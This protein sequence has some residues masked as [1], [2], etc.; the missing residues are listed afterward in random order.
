MHSTPVPAHRRP[1]FGLFLAALAAL[2]GPLAAGPALSQPATGAALGQSAVTA[3][4]GLTWAQMEGAFAG[5]VP[6][7]DA[8]RTAVHT[9][10]ETAVTLT[11]VDQEQVGFA[12][13]ELLRSPVEAGAPAPFPA[14][15]YLLTSEFD[16]WAA[17]YCTPVAVAPWGEGTPERCASTMRLITVGGQALTADISSMVLNMYCSNMRGGPDFRAAIVDTVTELAARAATGTDPIMTTRID[18]FAAGAT[19]CP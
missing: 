2:T 8:C 12:Y 13:A 9:A 14:V 1:A 5:P 18:N 17:L 6:A 3:C 11:A 7:V 4:A 19:A 10:F 15:A 16:G